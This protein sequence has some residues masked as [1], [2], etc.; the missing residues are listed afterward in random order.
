MDFVFTALLKHAHPV[1]S[2]RFCPVKGLIR[3]LN[4]LE[5]TRAMHGIKRQ[6]DA[7]RQFFAT[8]ILLFLERG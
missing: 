8:D 3:A 7:Y 4:E 6:P 1:P 5:V 2:F